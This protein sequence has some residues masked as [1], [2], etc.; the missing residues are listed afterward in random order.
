ML[1]R[2]EKEAASRRSTNN[3]Q[4][5]LGCYK[6]MLLLAETI[7]G[8][9]KSSFADRRQQTL[10]YLEQN[11]SSFLLIGFD[12]LSSYQTCV[13]CWKNFLNMTREHKKNAHKIKSQIDWARVTDLYALF[14]EETS[15]KCVVLDQK[16]NLEH[17]QL[18][19]D[20][21]QHDLSSIQLIYWLPSIIWSLIRCILWRWFQSKAKLSSWLEL[22]FMIEICGQWQVSV[23]LEITVDRSTG[24]ATALRFTLWQ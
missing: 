5:P 3:R 2:L 4:Q 14:I 18:M 6:Q 21:L 7:N 1:N 8:T 10:A 20:R 16:E 19:F 12:I 13:H 24:V 23:Q 11:R 22:W 15:R 9:R 17:F